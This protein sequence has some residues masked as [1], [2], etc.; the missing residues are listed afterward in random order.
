MGIEPYNQ[1]F[2]NKTAFAEFD[3]CG[4]QRLTSHCPISLST[5]MYVFNTPQ[6][7]CWF[8]ACLH[9]FIMIPESGKR[10]CA[11]MPNFTEMSLCSYKCDRSSAHKFVSTA[12][13]TMLCEWVAQRGLTSKGRIETLF[14]KAQRCI[15][16][17][18][19]SAE[20]NKMFAT[21]ETKDKMQC[22][23]QRRHKPSGGMWL[24]VY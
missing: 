21:D 18:Q 15:F 22:C 13:F 19:M 2:T 8:Q 14:Y 23:V 16:I 5:K 24:Y 12:L 4:Q 1:Q 7:R 3:Y 6:N 10:A 20:K 11:H 17:S 9:P